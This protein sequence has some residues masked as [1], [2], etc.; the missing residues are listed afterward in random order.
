MTKK[1]QKPGPKP[2]V[3]KIE[4][5]DWKQAVGQ[6]TKVKRPED[7]WPKPDGDPD[8]AE[9]SPRGKPE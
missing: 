6:A 8:K 9:S 3:L 4:A 5:D 1:K 2:D 7:G